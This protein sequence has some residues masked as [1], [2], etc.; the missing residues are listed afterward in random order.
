MQIYQDHH[1]RELMTKMEVRSCIPLVGSSKKVKKL[2]SQVEAACATDNA[3]LLVGE[4]GSMKSRVAQYI[5]EHGRAK[6]GVVDSNQGLQSGLFILTKNK[7]LMLH[8]GH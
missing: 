7:L 2:R 6:D 8:I 4:A 1:Y 3:V 5:Y